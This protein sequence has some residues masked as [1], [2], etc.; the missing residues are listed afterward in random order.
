M[1]LFHQIVI[2]CPHCSTLMQDCELMSYTVHGSSA[3]YSD[4]KSDETSSMSAGEEI[5][6]CRQC[7]Q[8][9]WKTESKVAED[10]VYRETM[11]NLQ[12]PSDLFD[13]QTIFDDDWPEPLINRYTEM[14]EN[15]FAKTDE[16]EYYVRT[17]IWWSIN[18]YIRELPGWTYAR[19]LKQ[20]NAIITQRRISKALFT[21]Y[22]LLLVENLDRLIFLYIK[23]VD[24]DL[25]FLANMYRE[26]ENFLKAK[27]ILSKVENKREK[28]YRKLKCKTRW[29]NSRVF[30]IR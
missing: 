25:L 15:G 23:S 11:K 29:N 27:D 7:N 12:E 16:Q 9:F 13:L 19:N 14:I 8:P 22:Q 6:A 21:K 10:Q 30:Q 24:V 2:K 28:L 17:R 5:K 1:T 18:D 20:L 3:C 26:Q 4:G